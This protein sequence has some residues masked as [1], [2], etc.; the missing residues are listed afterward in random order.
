MAIS[1]IQD[2]I[3]DIKAGKMVVLVDAEAARTKAIW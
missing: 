3:A 2:I 1:P